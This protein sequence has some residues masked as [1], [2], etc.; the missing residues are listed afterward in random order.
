[1]SISESLYFIY[2]NINFYEQFGIINVHVENNLYEEPFLAN[3][4]I[5]E[6]KIKNRSEP[7]FQNIE[8]S[9]LSLKLSFAFEDTFDSEKIRAIA[10]ALKKDFYCPLVFSENPDRIFYCICVDES[11]LIHN[12]LGN[13]YVVLNFRCNSSYSYS[14]VYSSPIYDL[15]S[16][17]A[18]GT[19]ISITNN[20]DLPMPILINIQIINGSSFSITNISD[21]GKSI[22]FTGLDVA[23]VLEVNTENESITS[24]SSYRYDNMEGEF[25]LL[26]R[27]V[28]KLLIKGKIK[29]QFQYQ[30]RLLQS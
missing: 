18:S 24:T 4:R 5:N 28:S 9:P 8:E 6:I 7:Y 3:R 20:G 26:N 1:M 13:G 10:R 11:Q 23:E 21:A 22:S 25:L 27:G 2:D 12:G 15:T 17:P 19:E 16:N 14:P 29:L 30:F